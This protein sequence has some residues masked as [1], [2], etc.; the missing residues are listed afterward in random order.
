MI[1]ISRRTDIMLRWQVAIVTENPRVL[2]LVIELLKKLDLKFEVC[3]PG[4]S[5][6]EDAKVVITT[7]EDSNNHDAIVIVDEKI[8]PDFT[9]IEIM[10]KL[11]DI[12]NPSTAVI[13]IDPGM[14]FG[15][16]LVID[17][18]VTFKNSLSSPG[19]AARLSSRLESYVARLFPDCKTIVRAGTGSKLYSTLYLRDMNHQFPGLDVELVNE[20]HTT[21]SGGVT[22][23]QT[24]AIL[25][26]GRSG[27]PHTENDR[28]LEPKEGYVKSLKL[29]VQRFTRGK[30]EISKDE[31]R[32]ILLGETSLD[33]ILTND[34]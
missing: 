23:D 13:G 31:A 1:S 19:D 17:G 3:S 32:A 18:V 25:I 24:S 6:C 27:R 22:S 8:D 10:S 30:R 11:N 14:R 26:A 28:V 33:C 20:H 29:F 12:H 34:C 7:L 21:L 5:R 2:Y 9:S 16:A 15:V 4:D